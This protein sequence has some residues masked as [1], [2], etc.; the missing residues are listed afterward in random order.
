M[1]W[2]NENGLEFIYCSQILTPVSFIY[3]FIQFNLL[4]WTLQNQELTDVSGQWEEVGKTHAGK[5][6]GGHAN[7]SRSEPQT[8]KV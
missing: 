7:S 2:N 4:S 3:Y 5:E 8:L 6:K 1:N